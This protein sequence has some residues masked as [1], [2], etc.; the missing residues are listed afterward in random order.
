MRTVDDSDRSILLALIDK[1]RSSIAALAER[2]RLARNTVQAR[3]GSMEERGVLRNYDRRVHTPAI[4]YPLTVFMATHV[5]QHKLESVAARLKHVPEIIQAHGLAG[6]ADI[7]LR[8][9]CKDT[10]DLYRINK[11]VLAVDGVV[12]TETWLSVGELIP[13]DLSRILRRDR[14]EAS[15]HDESQQSPS[16]H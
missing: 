15:P 5:D 4:G 13:F 2:L 3:L 9:A 6:Q 8:L 1:P 14:G 7:L 11:T 10:D 16:E 12:R